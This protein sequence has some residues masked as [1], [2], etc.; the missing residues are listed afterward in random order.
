MRTI[1]PWIAVAVLAITNAFTWRALSEERSQQAPRIE[2]RSIQS[3]MATPCSLMNSGADLAQP[4]ARANAT[5]MAQEDATVTP[6]KGS[7][8]IPVDL[9]FLK[10]RLANQFKDPALHEALRENQRNQVLRMY[11]ELLK[12]WHASAEALDALSDFQ[13]RTLT[14]SETHPSQIVWE[15][16]SVQAALT[17]QQLDELRDYTTTRPDRVAI[18][19]W[20]TGLEL[21]NMSLPADKA[22]ELIHMMSEERTAAAPLPWVESGN[23]YA[24]W[25]AELDERILNRATDILSPDQL[26]RFELYQ[27]GQ[28]TSI[29]L[30]FASG[31]QSARQA[32]PSR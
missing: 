15:D 25:R 21:E 9:T 4:K 12:K 29:A 28:R 18:N 3:S 1:V 17:P 2:P 8:R 19:A 10:S 27:R 6:E 11:G 32:A 24:D 5:A 7:D 23:A 26:S 31:A 22:E 14:N 13:L 30:L 16:V 20:L